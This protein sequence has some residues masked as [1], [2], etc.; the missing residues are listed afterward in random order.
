[1]AGENNGMNFQKAMQNKQV[2]GAVAGL[3]AGIIKDLTDL[4]F[5]FL[6]IIN[7]HFGYLASGLFSSPKEANSIFGW[8]DG[9][10]ANFIIDASLG[11]VFM[12]LIQSD[13]QYIKTKGVFFGAVVWLLILGALTS[14]HITTVPTKSAFDGFM[15]FFVHILYGFLLGLSVD[16]YGRKAL[17]SKV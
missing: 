9:Y 16:K 1:M 14:F 10:L 12:Y 13:P 3:I 7:K 17:N 8:I 2:F 6:G 5:Y 11:V 15:N 4:T